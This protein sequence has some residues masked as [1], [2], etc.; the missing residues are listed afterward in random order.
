MRV[1]IFGTFDRLHDGHRF[2][3]REASARGDLTVIVARDHNVE[4]IKSKRPQETEE[5]RRQAIQSAFPDADVRLGDNED[6]LA[7]VRAAQP[8]LILLGYDQTLPPGVTEEM[9]GCPVE[10]LGSYFPEMYKSSLQQS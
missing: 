6:F 2:V 8:D 4:A 10:R 3:L 1:M 5:A 9:L 7:P